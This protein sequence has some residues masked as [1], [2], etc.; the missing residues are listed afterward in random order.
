M[1]LFSCVKSI[2]SFIDTVK[3]TLV[4][5]LP[6]KLRSVKHVFIVFYHTDRIL[7]RESQCFML[8]V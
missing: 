7:K 8:Y 2:C 4:T 1:A 5:S 3:D 6:I